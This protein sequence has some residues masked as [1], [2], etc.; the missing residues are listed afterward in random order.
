VVLRCCAW[1]LRGLS[2]S[3]GD[4]K[5]RASALPGEGRAGLR[6]LRAS[7]SRGR[8]GSTFSPS[9]C[10][11]RSVRLPFSRCYSTPCTHVTI[12]EKKKEKK[13]ERKRKTIKCAIVCGVCPQATE[14]VHDACVALMHL[15]QRKQKLKTEE[16]HTHTHASNMC[17]YPA[18][19]ARRRPERARRMRGTH[20]PGALQNSTQGPAQPQHCAPPRGLSPMSA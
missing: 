20:A 13:K 11:C 3:G 2:G 6:R 7:V 16:K 14:S 9:I 17:H 12:V 18:G 5:V 19:C 1:S 15:A 8:K 10:L 4:V